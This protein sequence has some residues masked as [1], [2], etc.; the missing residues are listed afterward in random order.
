MNSKKTEQQMLQ[1][2][3]DHSYYKNMQLFSS[4]IYIFLRKIII[5]VSQIIPTYPELNAKILYANLFPTILTSR[6]IKT[7]LDHSR[8]QLWCFF[9]RE[10]RAAPVLH[11]LLK[12]VLPLCDIFFKMDTDWPACYSA[13]SFP[14]SLQYYR[15]FTATALLSHMT[16]TPAWSGSTCN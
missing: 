2:Q 8:M 6:R 15:N 4:F 10:Q 16:H 11:R 7:K 5:L 3:P 1:S 9:V 14:H 13:I 12:Q